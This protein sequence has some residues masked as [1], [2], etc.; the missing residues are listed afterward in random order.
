MSVLQRSRGCGS[1]DVEDVA[2][3]QAAGWHPLT[4]TTEWNE[5]MQELIEVHVFE[6]EAA[7]LL[8]V[9]GPRDGGKLTRKLILPSNDP[10][11]IAVGRL[12]QELIAK[13][14]RFAFI[15]WAFRRK[16]SSLEIEQA[17]LF[18]LLVVPYHK[19]AGEISGISYDESTA[20]P[21]CKAGATQ[22]VDLRL[23][24]HKMPTS[25]DVVRTLAGTELL[26]SQGLAEHLVAARLTGFDLRRVWNKAGPSEGPMALQDTRAGQ[27]LLRLAALEDLVPSEWE[28]QVWLNREGNRPLVAQARKEHNEQMRRRST[29]RA[30][31]TPRW[32]QI[33]PHEAHVRIVT[34]TRA[35]ND[36]FDE[37]AQGKYK[38]PTGDTIG[39]RLLSELTVE[40]PSSTLPD[41]IDTDRFTGVR[42]G[43]FRPMRSTLISQ[44]FREVLAAAGAKGFDLEV[45]HLKQ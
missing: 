32:Y 12:H 9:F 26:V 35:G 8:E 28:F 11:L 25:R 42:Q 40:I 17:R 45:V 1:A 14:N 7:H 41:L 6:R 22:R 44:R 23:D 4:G 18:H 31:M 16:Y 43:V 37:D 29:K 30:G 13:S 24:L 36:P 15:S 39:F 10:R 34:P 33:R 19:V 3:G 38:C 5:S 20:C 27:E 2:E 21:V